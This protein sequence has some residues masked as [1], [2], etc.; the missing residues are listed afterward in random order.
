MK[1][2][3]MQARV[4]NLHWKLTLAYLSSPISSIHYIVNV[5]VNESYI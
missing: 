2:Y 5:I 4:S 3:A 1:S